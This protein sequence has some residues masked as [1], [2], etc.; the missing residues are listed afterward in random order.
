MKEQSRLLGETH[1][2]FGQFGKPGIGYGV[3]G[4][5]Q[6]VRHILGTDRTWGAVLVGV[7]RLG[8]ALARYKGF[9]AKGIRLVAVLDNDPELIGSSLGPECSLTVRGFDD[10]ETVASELD[11]FLPHVGRLGGI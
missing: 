2:E 10:L 6:R 7:G 4:L 11:E 8:N 5:I 9:E 3:E 1:R